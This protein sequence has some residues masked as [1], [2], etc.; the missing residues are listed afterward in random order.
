MYAPVVSFILC[1]LTLI[2]ALV[3]DWSIKHGD[4]IAAFLNGDIDRD[5]YVQY[6]YNIPAY[7]K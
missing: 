2:I 3:S 5:L 1:I 4:V 6:P 7:D